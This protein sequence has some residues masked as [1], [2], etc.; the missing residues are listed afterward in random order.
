MSGMLSRFELLRLF[1]TTGLTLRESLVRSSSA[2]EAAW[3]GWDASR[4]CENAIIGGL[5]V[6]AAAI[7]GRVMLAL[8][9]VSAFESSEQMNSPKPRDRFTLY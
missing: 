5:A 8:S 3:D 2:N 7:A 6:W 4:S 1:A 9:L